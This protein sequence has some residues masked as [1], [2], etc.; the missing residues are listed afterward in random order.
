MRLVGRCAAQVQLAR[1]GAGQAGFV[2]RVGGDLHLSGF[3]LQ[4]LDGAAYVQGGGRAVL[5][6]VDIT[7][8]RWTGATVNGA[9]SALTLRRARVEGTQPTPS[10]HQGWG[11]LAER[12][13]TLVLED[14]VVDRNQGNNLVV[15]D[16]S[17]QATLTRVLVR[18]GL[19]AQIDGV[20]VGL[21]VAYGS[22]ADLH[23][24]VFTRNR[25]RNLAMAG[26]GTTAALEHC[27]LSDVREAPVASGAWLLPTHV[28]VEGGAVATLSSS[29][30]TAVAAH[31]FVVDPGSRIEASQVV[32][33]GSTTDA[34]TAVYAGAQASVRLNRSAIVEA[35]SLGLGLWTGDGEVRDSLIT[36][37]HL[38]SRGLY[39]VGIQARDGASLRVTGS[40]MVDNAAVGIIVTGQGDGGVPTH[41][42]IDRTL[43]LDTRTGGSLQAGHGVNVNSGGQ[44]ELTHSALSG[45]HEVGL[46]IA[47]GVA[48]VSDTVVR[49]TRRNGFEEFGHGIVGVVDA[50]DQ[51]FGTTLHLARVTVKDN[52]S[53]GLFADAVTAGVAACVFEGNQTAVHAQKGTELVE[54]A[55]VPGTLTPLHLAV[56]T[57][58]VFFGNANVSGTGTLPLPASLGG[59]TVS[60]P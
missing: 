35:T 7:Q 9:G 51:P 24:C 49:D 14:V 17:T 30:L 40:A 21:S 46:S 38:D 44:L 2:V 12:G 11:V 10:G 39:G 29:H 3:T 20:G 60:A 32:L 23:E 48:T 16:A 50:V 25:L 42:V 56:S 31:L 6:D 58:T 59:V 22:H 4:A 5:E 45:N 37:T 53:V 1:V 41:A 19:Q 27:V 8:S 28:A 34:F 54:V 52:A 55:T 57:D 47:G 26:A 43:V 36:G 15:K 18:D 33:R 13:S